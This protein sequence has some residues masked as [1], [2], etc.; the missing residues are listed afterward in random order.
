MD[1]DLMDCSADFQGSFKASNG[2]DDVVALRSQRKGRTLSCARFEGAQERRRHL[3]ACHTSH[4]CI[5]GAGLA[6]LRCAEVLIEL[7]MRV[8]ILEARDRIGGRVSLLR[9]HNPILSLTL[10]QISQ[11]E[12][13]GRSIDM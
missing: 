6:G 8:T 7:D 2:I 11:V 4:I 9:S 3:S 10:S 13:S 5:I 1:Q 12:L